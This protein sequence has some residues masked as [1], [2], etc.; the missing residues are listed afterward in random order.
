MKDLFNELLLLAE[1]EWAIHTS[2]L[3]GNMLE[4][5]NRCFIVL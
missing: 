5:K 1:V 3:Y 2:F 4:A